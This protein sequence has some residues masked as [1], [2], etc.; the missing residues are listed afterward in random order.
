MPTLVVYV[1]PV[2]SVERGGNVS[3]IYLHRDG[4]VLGII[5]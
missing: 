3:V 1:L 5:A 4:N 2:K